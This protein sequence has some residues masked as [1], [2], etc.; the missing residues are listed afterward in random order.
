MF[1]QAQKN[2]KC[3]ITPRFAQRGRLDG[4][5]P[6]RRAGFGVGRSAPYGCP[7]GASAV[8]FQKGSSWS[9]RGVG[10]SGEGR[11]GKARRFRAGPGGAGIWERRR[12]EGPRLRCHPPQPPLTAASLLP[13]VRAGSGEGK[14]GNFGPGLKPAEATA[15]RGESRSQEGSPPR[16]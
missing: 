3:K 6:E 10:G 15:V 12:E 7:P 13:L 11:R 5:R 14:R 1:S 2:Q 8:E 4:N 16:T 9:P